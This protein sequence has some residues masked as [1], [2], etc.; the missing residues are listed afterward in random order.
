V[1]HEQVFW[2]ANG[3]RLPTAAGTT[4]RVRTGTAGLAR[5]EAD[6]LWQPAMRGQQLEENRRAARLPER[7][8]GRDDRPEAEARG[9]TVVRWALKG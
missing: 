1:T 7:E 3:Y 6:S 4:L 5:S 9:G 2:T 8:E